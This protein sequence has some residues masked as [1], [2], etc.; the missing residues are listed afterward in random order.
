MAFWRSVG[1]IPHTYSKASSLRSCGQT[2]FKANT[3]PRIRWHRNHV[4]KKT[5]FLLKNGHLDFK[6]V[7]GKKCLCLK[8]E[9]ATFV[10]CPA[11]SL[12]QA[13]TSKRFQRRVGNLPEKYFANLYGWPKLWSK[14]NGEEN[15]SGC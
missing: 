2:P 4:A 3:G 14:T 10:Y 7:L 13:P 9:R 11:G 8:G 5:N 12:S 1:T 15:H 6:L